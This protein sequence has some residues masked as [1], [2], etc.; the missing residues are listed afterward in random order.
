MKTFL[1]F[2]AIVCA[3][4]L[5]CTSPA[6]HYAKRP[7][8]KR[9][10]NQSMWSGDQSIKTRAVKYGPN[11]LVKEVEFTDSIRPLGESAWKIYAY[12]QQ[13][14]YNSENN[15]SMIKH[16]SGSNITTELF[17][18]DDGV[19]QSRISD[20]SGKKDTTFYSYNDG[21]AMCTYHSGDLLYK[22][23]FTEG[24]T[25]SVYCYK[26]KYIIGKDFYYY[27]DT[28][29]YSEIPLPMGKLLRS[30]NRT[31]IKHCNRSVGNVSEKIYSYKYDK[32]Q[33][34]IEIATTRCGDYS[35]TKVSYY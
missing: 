18:Y 2:A 1:T 26:G 19:L 3:F 32:E 22:T 16:I 6:E 17:V 31:L 15:V 20:N 23:Y 13:F 9:I 24:K 28:T 10:R 25:D 5:Q 33:R 21:K 11:D 34:Q 12:S 29:D 7:K 14:S 27:S 35:V 4:F 8:I 30:E